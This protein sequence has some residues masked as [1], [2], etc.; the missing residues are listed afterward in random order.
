MNPQ[1]TVGAQ[2]GEASGQGQ[3]NLV[4]NSTDRRGYTSRAERT[5]AVTKREQTRAVSDT[6]SSMP[7]K[8]AAKGKVK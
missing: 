6:V 5:P 3:P 7:R 8:I 1:G 2:H 4:R